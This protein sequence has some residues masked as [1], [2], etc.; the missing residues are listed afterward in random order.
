MA[1]P[2]GDRARAARGWY[3]R[4]RRRNKRDLSEHTRQGV[5]PL[6]PFDFGAV[7]AGGSSANTY[8]LPS[9][10]TFVVQSSAALAAGDIGITN[11]TD[12]V[13]AEAIAAG[14]FVEI[15]HRFRRDQGIQIT[16]DAGAPA[17]SIDVFFLEEKGGKRTQIGEATF[18]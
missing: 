18:T 12:F 6:A 10:G 2:T 4:E 15:R 17:S 16:R 3:A 9:N 8:T 13:S 1:T 14:G 11:G 5:T 7:A